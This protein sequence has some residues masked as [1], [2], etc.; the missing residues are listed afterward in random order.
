MSITRR[1]FLPWLLAMPLT[2][3]FPRRWC[4]GEYE[5]NGKIYFHHGNKT[6]VVWPD[7]DGPLTDGERVRARQLAKDY[8]ARR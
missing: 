3:L 2:I 7:S 4:Y 5:E 6:F 1:G 8:F